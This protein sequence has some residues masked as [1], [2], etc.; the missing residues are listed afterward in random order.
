MNSDFIAFF[1]NHGDE[2]VTTIVTV[3]ILPGIAYIAFN[4][5]TNPPQNR[6]ENNIT[7]PNNC[8]F[9]QADTITIINQ[10]ETEPRSTLT[11]TEKIDVY[12][13]SAFSGVFDFDYSNNNGYYQ[14]GSGQYTFTTKWSKASDK[15]IHA[16]SDGVDIDAIGLANTLTN[17]IKLDELN[18]VETDFSS[19]TRTPK[20]GE[21]VIWKNKNGKYAITKVMEIDDDNR[22]S[23]SD[24]LKCEFIIIK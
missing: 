14:I 5:K 1:N 17:N 15:S 3:I 18:L 10:V 8:N 21:S 9:N 13:N 7:N 6:I 24:R 11:V 4:K 20:I 2:I 22:G 16:Y 23:N 19:R 12:I